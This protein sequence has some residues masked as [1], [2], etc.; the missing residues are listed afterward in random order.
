MG[1]IVRTKDGISV[2]SSVLFATGVS[3]LLVSS[4][5]LA[6]SAVAL[7]K[8][9]R[10]P[11][12]TISTE[13]FAWL[14]N[15]KVVPA[16]LPIQYDDGTSLAYPS[17]LTW[18]HFDVPVSTGKSSR[19]LFAQY[20]APKSAPANRTFDGGT[21]HVVARTEAGAI[22][23]QVSFQSSS[24]IFFS[25]DLDSASELDK[26]RMQEMYSALR[27]T[28][29]VSMNSHLPD[30]SDS[31]TLVSIQYLRL[32]SIP[33]LDINHVS[34]LEQSAARSARKLPKSRRISVA[35]AKKSV[36]APRRQT[37]S[38]FGDSH[39]A[40]GVS[41][42]VTSR[43][44]PM[45]RFS[46]RS[47][48]I[49]ALNSHFDSAV[50]DA[51]IQTDRLVAA[52]AWLKTGSS[53]SEVIN[54]G[55]SLRVGANVLASQSVQSDQVT[56][57]QGHP[58]AA[59]PVDY[60]GVASTSVQIAL[61][62]QKSVSSGGAARVALGNQM[63]TR[64][65]RGQT[66]SRRDTGLDFSDASV[67][68]VKQDSAK[69]GRYGIASNL[70]RDRDTSRSFSFV[71]AFASAYPVEGVATESLTRQSG[72]RWELSRAF[73]HIA[74]LARVDSEQSQQTIPM[75]SVN[76]ARLL[77]INAGVKIQAEAGI[78]FGRVPAGWTVDFRGRSER[79]MFFDMSLR[80]VQASATDQPRH[81]L[82]LNAAPGAQLIQVSRPD[83]GSGSIAIPVLNATAT[84]VDL[85]D[86]RL[87]QAK[88]AVYNGATDQAEGLAQ[89]RVRVAG[90]AD[91]ERVTDLR[92][93]FVIDR[94]IVAGSYPVVLETDAATGYT[95]R[96]QVS[97]DRIGGLAL[98]RMADDQVQNWIGQLEGGVSPES[99]MI[100]AA[101]SQET[102]ARMERKVLYPAARTLSDDA[103]LK[104]E[105]YAVSSEGYLQHKEA[106]NQERPR[107]V[108][109]QV[110]EGPAVV[111]ARNGA[112]AVEWS[113]MV[114]AQS[115]IINVVG[116]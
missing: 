75:I 113:E 14:A 92:G 31:P 111:E 107:I 33:E 93:R 51:G 37:I 41:E 58:L 79:A 53:S 56:S 63:A 38:A 19:I 21:Y 39:M 15:M 23:D 42:S 73:E 29:F 27:R 115:A 6:S 82:Y 50:R 85:S 74:T 104:P 24:P 83:L 34:D 84:Y 46:P 86:V 102:I 22:A 25:P 5:I 80:P 45:P 1:L 81:F 108:S 71:E 91:S 28:F 66:H 52:A 105:S 64:E 96:Y 9:N 10:A 18:D 8:L 101:V 116:P 114:F 60:S 89:V 44:Q 48:S 95:H 70:D 4:A 7:Q 72:S 88:G 97:P 99:G 87:V 13:P 16:E 103:T 54:D 20:H 59:G 94:V 90:G 106:L 17:K 35:A 68:S 57:T 11:A 61:N 49:V 62:T 109:V 110:P 77:A 2:A 98:F 47:N 26:L 100:V 43:I 67:G 55:D 32:D 30:Q 69:D 36:V 112:G 65:G 12:V 78:V 76:N 40:S 3:A